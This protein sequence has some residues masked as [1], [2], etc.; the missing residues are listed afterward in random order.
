MEH[1]EDREHGNTSVAVAG[2]SGRSEGGDGRRGDF[3]DA[4]DV[5]VI[6]VGTTRP[7]GKRAL[8]A[9]VGLMLDDPSSSTWSSNERR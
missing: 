4:H 8:R 1:N 7:R 6:N 2:R 9:C 3:P 5:R